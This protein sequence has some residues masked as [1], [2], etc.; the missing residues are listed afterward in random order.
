MV[1]GVASSSGRGHPF[2]GI[3][4]LLL[5]TTAVFLATVLATRPAAG[6][7]V[8]SEVRLVRETKVAATIVAL[9][10]VASVLPGEVTV[11]PE[12]GTI[13]VAKRDVMT[14]ESLELGLPAILPSGALPEPFTVDPIDRPV[15]THTAARVVG[16]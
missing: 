5:F 4:C 3:G 2:L 1:W 6:R 14:V 11:G 10:P 9:D 12:G 7:T 13:F 8:V 16:I 15:E